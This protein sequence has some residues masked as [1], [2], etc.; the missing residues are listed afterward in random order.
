[1]GSVRHSSVFSRGACPHPSPRAATPDRATTHHSASLPSYTDPWYTPSRPHPHL[2]STLAPLS[3]TPPEMHP[4][5]AP[6]GVAGA[7]AQARPA[8]H[9]AARAPGGR[10]SGTLSTVPAA[11]PHG[12]SSPLA[13][14][15][16]LL[17]GRGLASAP[18]PTPPGVELG[19]LQDVSSRYHLG[20]TIGSG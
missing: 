19:W 14:V 20:R 18:P 17:R 7:P 5:T 9:R 4:A 6:S 12:D 2:G 13:A 10:R 16:S 15:S 8:L 11:L 1:M 3:H